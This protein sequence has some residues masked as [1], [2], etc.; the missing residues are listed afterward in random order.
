MWSIGGHKYGHI[1]EEYKNDIGLASFMATQHK[2]ES[3][4]NLHLE[5]APTRLTY[6]Q[7]YGVFS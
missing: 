6:G 7:A 2:V 3:F 1:T 5:N 4:G